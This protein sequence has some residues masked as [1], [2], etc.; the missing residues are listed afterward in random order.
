MNLVRLAIAVGVL[1]AL[2][3]PIVLGFLYWLARQE[4]PEDLRL[5][6][7]YAAAVG[8]VFSIVVLLVS[9]QAAQAFIV[10]P[11][12]LTASFWGKNAGAPAFFSC[13]G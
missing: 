5:R 13:C 10:G 2:L 1:N 9:M 11:Q 7:P 4:L 6:G 8:I 3:L 12:A